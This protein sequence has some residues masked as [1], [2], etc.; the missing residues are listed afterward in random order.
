MLRLLRPSCPSQSHLLISIPSSVVRPRAALSDGCAVPDIAFTTLAF[1]TKR[2]THPAL[3]RLHVQHAATDGT[4][5]ATGGVALA[6]DVADACGGDNEV[7]FVVEGQAELV[8][9][10]SKQ[11]GVG[12]GASSSS[13]YAAPQGETTGRTL[14]LCSLS[15]GQSF[16][17]VRALAPWRPAD[18]PSSVSIFVRSATPL[19]TLSLSLDDI[20]ALPCAEPERASAGPVWHSTQV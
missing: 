19:V 14:V 7:S 6:T 1:L 15:P 8:A 17:D 4:E 5:H 12:G 16:G 11:Q 20:R 18:E 13:P 2:R 9:C 10:W 3:K